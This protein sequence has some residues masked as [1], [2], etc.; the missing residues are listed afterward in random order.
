[1][2]YQQP[3]EIKGAIG[4]FVASTGK[5]ILIRIHEK[6]EQVPNGSAAGRQY[7]EKKIYCYERLDEGDGLINENQFSSIS[8]LLQSFQ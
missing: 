7:D 4:V 8:E 2:L 1:M 3:E 6:V 5:N